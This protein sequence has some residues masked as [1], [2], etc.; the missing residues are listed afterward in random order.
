M[1]NKNIINILFFSN[2][3]DFNQEI[4]ECEFIINGVG[5][6]NF[7][8][9]YIFEQALDLFNKRTYDIVIVDF[10]TFNGVELLN[11]IVS[12]NPEQKTITINENLVCSVSAGCDYCVQHYHRRRVID[13]HNYEAILDIINNFENHK[14][15]YFNSF[16]NIVS[17]LDEVIKRFPTF[18]YDEQDHKII[19]S[20]KNSYIT[21][22]LVEICNLLDV[23]HVKY[24]IDEQLNIIL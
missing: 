8:N 11:K 13:I 24:R 4:Q 6:Y 9:S 1:I 17:I 16:G 5:E 3:K 2:Q 14:C 10:S 21:K 19:P 20:Q 7:E 22:D 15:K 23:S 12:K 18:T